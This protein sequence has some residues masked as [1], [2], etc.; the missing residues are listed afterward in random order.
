MTRATFLAVLFTLTLPRLVVAQRYEGTACTATGSKQL[1]GLR[2]GARLGNLDG[3]VTGTYS[4]WATSTLL[5]QGKPPACP[6]CPPEAEDDLRERTQFVHEWTCGYSAKQVSDG[7]PETAWCEGAKGPGVGE[8]LVARV[9]GGQPVRIWSGY[10]KSPALHAANAR[11]RKVNVYVLEAQKKED[12]EWG[13]IFGG[14]TVVAKGEVE[15][16]DVNGYQELKLPAF[17]PNPK[18]VGTLVALEVVSIY[19]GKKYQDLCI[20]ELRTPDPS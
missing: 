1:K 7:N 4:S 12:N 14:L 17:T 2:L 15:L 16:A 9:E 20:S 6:E 10:G 8:V 19:P 13:Y 18:A 3:T 5:P 11:P